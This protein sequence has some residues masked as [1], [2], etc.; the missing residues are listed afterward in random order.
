M[1]M[2]RRRYN[3]SLG[4]FYSHRK[5]EKNGLLTNTL[6][7][8]TNRISP[9]LLQSLFLDINSLRRKMEDMDYSLQ[10]IHKTQLI[11]LHP[12][13]ADSTHFP[14]L[15]KAKKELVSL[16][17]SITNFVSCINTMESLPFYSNVV[18]SSGNEES[19]GIDY[20]ESGFD[21]IPCHTCDCSSLPSVGDEKDP[22]QPNF[23]HQHPLKR[24]STTENPFYCLSF[25]ELVIPPHKLDVLSKPTNHDDAPRINNNNNSIIKNNNN[26]N[27]IV[28]T[29][30]LQL[31]SLPTEVKYH[32]LSFISPSDYRNCSLV[33][34]GIHQ[35]IRT[36]RSKFPVKVDGKLSNH[37]PY[38]LYLP[39]VFLIDRI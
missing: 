29:T 8:S 21:Y 38:Y 26:Q 13:T 22:N 18:S 12:S 15:L 34:K 9:T 32:I 33:C 23:Y 7:F 5:S 39:L 16:Q 10:F 30:A 17:Q 19:V 37:H 4:G 11:S 36:L 14:L 27:T 3:H 25:Q 24:R 35:L 6:S 2:K 1:E 31:L 20:M 28:S